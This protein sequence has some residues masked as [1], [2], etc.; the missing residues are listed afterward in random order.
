MMHLTARDR[1]GIG[2]S[3]ASA[4]SSRRCFQAIITYLL[5]ASVLMLRPDRLWSKSRGV[6]ALE[7]TALLSVLVTIA[8]RL[9]GL[10]D[11]WQLSLITIDCAILFAS[12]VGALLCVRTTVQERA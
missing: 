3:T 6:L 4:Q 5:R 2:C 7:V 10:G 11:D 12:F 8:L 1:S 9:G